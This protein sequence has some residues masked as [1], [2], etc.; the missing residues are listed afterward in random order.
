MTPCFNPLPKP[1]RRTFP[2]SNSTPSVSPL[3][4]KCKPPAA[5]QIP[6]LL[7]LALSA[8]DYIGA[9]PFSPAATFAV[10]AKLDAAFATLLG[11]R[12]GPI[13]VYGS[14]SHLCRNYFS[15]S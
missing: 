2:L 6:F 8:S 12:R 9:F 13:A 1:F 11:D 14:D 7:T 3:L 4:T 15:S 10:F 5:I